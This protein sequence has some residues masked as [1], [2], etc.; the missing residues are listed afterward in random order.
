MLECMEGEMQTNVTEQAPDPR[1]DDVPAI[2][3]RALTK[4]YPGGTL[5]VD[6]LDLSVPRGEFFGLLGPNGAGKTTTVGML[7]TRV[8][9]TSGEMWISGLSVRKQEV[10]VKRI[11]GVLTQFKT[12]DS[13]LTTWENL[14]YHSRYFGLTRPD[15]REQASRVLALVR[16]T[17][18]SRTFV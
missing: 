6:R 12:L 2:S 16:L 9:P 18:K 15:A 5:A 17:E 13:R 3:T 4:V 7:T 10:A 11:I 8:V 14:Y 1:V